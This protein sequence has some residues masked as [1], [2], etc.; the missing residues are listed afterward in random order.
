[1]PYQLLADMVLIFH[2]ALALFLVV[3]SVLIVAGNLRGW[4]WVNTLWFRLFHLATVAVVVSQAW[5][6]ALCPLTILEMRLR[7]KAGSPVYE[8]SFIA[9][10][11]HRVLYYDG[12]LWVFVLVYTVFGLAVSALWWYFPPRNPFRK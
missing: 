7:L 12:P 6:G 1:M 4:G 5:L 8:G 9:Y 3:G 2:V 11:L 10:W